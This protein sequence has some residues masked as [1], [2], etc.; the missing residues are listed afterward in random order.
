MKNLISVPLE[1]F[2]NET[3]SSKMKKL[4]FGSIITYKRTPKIIKVLSNAKVFR[5]DLQV[6]MI[7]D[8]QNLGS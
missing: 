8:L 3:L 4:N 5:F 6:P 7:D 2:E 1:Q